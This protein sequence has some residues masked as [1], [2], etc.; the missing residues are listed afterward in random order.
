MPSQPDPRVNLGICLDRAGRSNDAMA[1][2]E[3]ALEISPE[4]LPAIQGAA[5]LSVRTGRNEQRLTAWLDSIAL[6][7]RRAMEP[8]GAPTRP[9][10]A[11]LLSAL[12]RSPQPPRD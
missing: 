12:S 9:Q 3:A 5:L 1:S 2:F 11:T 4:H 10:S 7:G 8:M 6:G